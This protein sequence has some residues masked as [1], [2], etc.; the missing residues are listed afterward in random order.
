MILLKTMVSCSE[1]QII[2]HGIIQVVVGSWNGRIAT[3]HSHLSVPAGR[4]KTMRG[5]RD[6]GCRE[7]LS[8][9]LARMGE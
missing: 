7:A 1:Y 6:G 4:A 2:R 3:T 8:G 9:C 5:S